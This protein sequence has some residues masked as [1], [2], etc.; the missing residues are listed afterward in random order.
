MNKETPDC[1]F[2]GVDTQAFLPS[3]TPGK[4]TAAGLTSTKALSCLGS[5]EAH[6]RMGPLRYAYSHLSKF[7]AFHSPPRSLNKIKPQDVWCVSWGTKSQALKTGGIRDLKYPKSVPFWSWAD[8]QW[9]ILRVWT[10]QDKLRINR[11]NCESWRWSRSQAV[12]AASS[13]ESG[14][15]HCVD[16]CLRC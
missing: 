7:T 2:L 3:Q 13:P 15:A 5:N 8:S 6:Y 1:R 11:D 4:L 9:R 14:T 12:T 10:R 16:K